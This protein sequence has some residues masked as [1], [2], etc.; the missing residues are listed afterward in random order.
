[1]LCSDCT[2]WAVE[3]KGICHFYAYVALHKTPS[4]ICL[5]EEHTSPVSAES[6]CWEFKLPVSLPN[7]Y[8]IRDQSKARFWHSSSCLA[9]ITD[10]K[11]GGKPFNSKEII[12]LVSGNWHFTKNYNDQQHR[13]QALFC[14]T[15]ISHHSYFL[16]T[17]PNTLA[18]W[19]FIFSEAIFQII[20]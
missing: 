3:S 14:P 12:W 7:K 17:L 18:L 8:P 1:M 13:M 5:T 19:F 2:F 4:V 10:I 16:R 20:P 11:N 6:L 9:S 15:L